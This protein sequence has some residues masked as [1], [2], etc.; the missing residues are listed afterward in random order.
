[1]ATEAPRAASPSAT[2]RSDRRGARDPRDPRGGRRDRR[3]GRGSW[4]SKCNTV[5]SA[6]TVF[7]TTWVCLK[8]VYP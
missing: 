1:M 2:V 4:R 5:I 3:D 7:L 6:I 8:I